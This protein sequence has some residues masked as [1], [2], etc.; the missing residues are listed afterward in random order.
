MKTRI[1][2]TNVMGDPAI[3]SPAINYQATQFN[4][5]IDYQGVQMAMEAQQRKGVY[6]FLRRDLFVTAKNSINIIG[7]PKNAR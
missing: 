4:R 7:V 3:L 6:P 2:I 1:C 5:I